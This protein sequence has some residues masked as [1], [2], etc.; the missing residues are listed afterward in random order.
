MKH[1]VF[2]LVLALLATQVWAERI[3][4][5]IH[6]VSLSEDGGPHIIRFASG[7]V[8][9][10]N[11][12]KWAELIT[13][14]YMHKRLS[15]EMDN[16]GILISLNILGPLKERVVEVELMPTPEAT[17]FTPTILSDLKEVKTV[18]KR[19]NHKYQRISQCYNR[20]HVWAYEE[21][22]KNG[23]HSM[24]SFVFFTNS[25]LR[26]TRFNWWFHVAPLIKTSDQ[27]EYVLDY[28]YAFGPYTIK[29]W[30]DLFVYSK[31]ECPVVAKY[32]EYNNN[33][34]L[35]DCY[36]INTSMFYWQPW[37]IKAN[38]ESGLI[39]NTFGDSEVKW[40]YKEAF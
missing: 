33:Q 17:A 35:Q 2:S 13:L 14:N 19:L 8:A 9:F 29:Q 21:F 38:E 37:E 18:F 10:T 25:Y 26:R 40:A 6:S 20:A 22:K 24:K 1:L 34:D 36:I 23:L 15:I 5:S 12:T 39:K 28:R 11:D 32:S 7:R 30:T 31:Q 16:E 27:N 3:Q 4:G